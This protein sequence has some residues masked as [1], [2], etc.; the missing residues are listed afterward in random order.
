MLPLTLQP[1]GL[2]LAAVVPDVR[3]TNTEVVMARGTTVI[4]LVA[5]LIGLAGPAMSVLGLDSECEF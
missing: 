1:L 2:S 3:L 4:L 5:F